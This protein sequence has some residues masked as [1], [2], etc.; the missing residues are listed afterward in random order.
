MI[1]SSI[2]HTVIVGFFAAAAAAC[3]FVSRFRS[4]F[5]WCFWLRAWAVG[6]HG[7]L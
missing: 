3:R 1:S 4:Q 2:C 7:W 6:W 5:K